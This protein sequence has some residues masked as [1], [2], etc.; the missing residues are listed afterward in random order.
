MSNYSKGNFLNPAEKTFIPKSSL[1]KIF[2]KTLSKIK[3][4][5]LFVSLF[6]LY[7]SLINYLNERKSKVRFFL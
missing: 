7:I 4:E 3:N 5:D 1:K 6:F 2:R